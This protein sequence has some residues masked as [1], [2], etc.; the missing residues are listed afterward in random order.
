MVQ[1]S[2]SNSSLEHGEVLGSFMDDHEEESLASTKPWTRS[3]S[4][5]ATYMQKAMLTAGANNAT[6]KQQ[7]KV[8]E[9]E[10]NA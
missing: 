2:Q 8:L 10:A 6:P 1:E 7:A 9:P 3:D 5:T 4:N